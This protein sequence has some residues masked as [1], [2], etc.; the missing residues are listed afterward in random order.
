[1]VSKTEIEGKNII[2]RALSRNLDY[3]G[4]LCEITASQGMGKTSTL[5]S[6]TEHTIM[7]HPTEKIFWR[8]QYNAPLQIFK[9]GKDKYHFMVKKG[10]NVIFRDR[11]KKLA[12]VE[13][14]PTYFKTYE[15]LYEK[16][17]P[18][19]AN[20]VFFGNAL[21]WMDFVTY[22]REAGEWVNIF[23]DE[24]ADVCPSTNSGRLYKKMNEFSGTMGAVRRCMMNLFYNTQTVAD[25]DWRIRKKVMMHIYMPGAIA[26]KRS[27]VK[28]RAIDNLQR[29]VE[30]G[31]EAYVDTG[32]V[33]G[34]VRF[35]DIFKPI[36]GIQLEAHVQP[37]NIKVPV[38]IEESNA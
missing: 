9:L 14:Y 12:H 24:M 8:E 34:K 37:V 18:S 1:M 11:N 38:N 31:N 4:I 10:S 21:K 33:F 19:I 27:R 28:Q 20:V 15:E 36:P 25:I 32:G 13:V 22:L 29:S 7:R 30:I 17:K 5:L 3:G 23:V 16:A 6:L 2:D 35:G 26:D